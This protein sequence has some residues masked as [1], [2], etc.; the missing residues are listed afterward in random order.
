MRE[1]KR[2]GASDLPYN[3]CISRYFMSG[4]CMKGDYCTFSHDWKDK[5]DTV[6]TDKCDY[7][8]DL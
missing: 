5:P 1:R 2:E 6:R 8:I 3:L 7:F 4:C